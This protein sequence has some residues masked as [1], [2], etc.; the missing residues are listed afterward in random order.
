MDIKW[1]Q[2]FL[3]LS[4]VLNFT[5]ASEIRNLSQ[6][7]FSRRIGSLEQMLGAKLIDRSSYPTRLTPA[8]E[9]FRGV[10][11][12]IV[13]QIAD[14][15]ADLA[16][17]QSRDK[18]KLAMPYALATTRLPGW[19]DS[20]T[21]GQPLICALETGNVHDI[22][23][24]FIAGN[25]DLLICFYHA[26]SPIQIDPLLFESVELGRERVRPYASPALIEKIGMHASLGSAGNPAPLLMYSSSVY[27]ARVVDQIIEGSEVKLEGSPMFETEM[28]DVLGDLAS[29]G[30]G[31][32]W[33][34]DSSFSQ[35]RHWSLEP[36]GGGAWD[37]EVSILAF[38]PKNN[39][40]PLV[41]RMWREI[42]KYK[43]MRV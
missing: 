5:R 9:K 27:F 32:A 31:V 26:A 34:P 20:W 39:L 29:Q 18:I 40:R 10:A 24:S 22:V 38:K 36:V 11:A 23:S 19:W 37:T 4:E 28:S 17:N 43:E 1:F 3:T 14:A 30:L 2:D 15:K 21:S 8:G 7:A 35:H 33:L 41:V 12:Q 16:G 13:S 6:A 25:V 42:L